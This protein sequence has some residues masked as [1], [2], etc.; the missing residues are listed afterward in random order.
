MYCD[1]SIFY[2]DSIN[3]KLTYQN[4]HIEVKHHVITDRVEMKE[5]KL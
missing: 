3:P 4:N 2:K 5:L 1:K